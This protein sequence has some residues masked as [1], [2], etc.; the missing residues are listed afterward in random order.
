MVSTRRIHNQYL[1]LFLRFGWIC[2]LFDLS[3]RRRIARTSLS[4]SRSLCHSTHFDL[5]V[6]VSLTDCSQFKIG[7]LLLYAHY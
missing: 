1:D 4:A 3:R 2:I 5:G 6:A 7:K